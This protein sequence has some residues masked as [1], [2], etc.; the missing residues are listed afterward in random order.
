M[1]YLLIKNQVRDFAQWE[2]EYNTHEEKRR[3]AS[4][5]DQLIL[6]NS[7]N[8]NEIFLLFK[9]GNIEKA[10]QFIQSD[11]LKQAMEKAGTVGEPVMYFLDEAKVPSTFI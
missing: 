2:A 9:V 7:E 4:L 11:E 6:R 10:Q 8:P 1:T 5:E 3:E